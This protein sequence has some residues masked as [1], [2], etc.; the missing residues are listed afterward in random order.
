MIG[1]HWFYKIG[2]E[3]NPCSIRISMFIKVDK[4][5]ISQN[6]ISQVARKETN[7]DFCLKKNL[8][9]KSWMFLV[10]CL[11]D[12]SFLVEKKIPAKFFHCCSIFISIACPHMKL[13][14]QVRQVEVNPTW[15]KG[16]LGLRI[17]AHP[18]LSLHMI[19]DC[20]IATQSNAIPIYCISIL[21]FNLYFVQYK[22][23]T[24]YILILLMLW[25][26]YLE[27]LPIWFKCWTV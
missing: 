18:K 3:Q 7:N 8:G 5:V 11:H 16:K 22:R 27:K 20:G 17:P 6:K 12:C 21:S 15:Q 10:C 1:P 13:G 24:T 19:V 23:I 9:C 2:H 14:Q 25:V 26:N 4:Y